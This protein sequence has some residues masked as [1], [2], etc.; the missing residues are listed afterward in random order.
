[1]IKAGQIWL[2]ECAVGSLPA[3]HA[4][5]LRRAN[6]VLYER[7]LG[8][9]VAEALPI[10]VY[11]E[12]LSATAGTGPAIAPRARQFAA[13]GWSVL[14]LVE[15]RGGWRRHLQSV[16]QE[17]DHLDGGAS[18]LLA[19]GTITASRYRE[20]RGGP[21]DLA[22]VAAQL[23]PDELLSLTFGLPSGPPGSRSPA[24]GQAFTANGLAG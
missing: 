11:A 10:G 21:T 23:R 14:L 6:V 13:D 12:P 24:R 15:Q 9:A 2:V 19:I 17:L 4:R 20:R 7:A 1:V 5:L 3:L 8:A 22:T 18:P 16:T